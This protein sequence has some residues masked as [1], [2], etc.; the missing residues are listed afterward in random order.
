MYTTLLYV[1]V[2]TYGTFDSRKSSVSNIFRMTIPTGKNFTGFSRLFVYISIHLIFIYLHISKLLTVYYVWQVY[3]RN[4]IIKLTYLCANNSYH[5][6]EFY[7][8]VCLLMM[9][10]EPHRL[11]IKPQIFELSLW[12]HERH[13]SR[14]LICVCFCLNPNGQITRCSANS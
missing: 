4:S 10:S 8:R 14:S 11:T 12:T 2:N 5:I 1:M 7:F 6:A 3:M 13:S 9:S